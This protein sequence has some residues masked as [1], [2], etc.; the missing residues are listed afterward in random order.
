MSCVCCES[1]NTNKSW[2]FVYLGAQVELSQPLMILREFGLPTWHT[3]V[4]GGVK[5]CEGFGGLWEV[6]E[7]YESD[8]GEEDVNREMITSQLQGKLW[9]YD[10]VRL[11]VPSFLPGD[12]PIAS[13]NKAMAFLSIAIASWFLCTNNQLRTSSNPRNQATAQ[14]GRVIV[15]Q[16]QGRQG[17]GYPKRLRNSVW[18][19]EKLMLVEAQEAVQI[20][21]KE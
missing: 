10:E 18:F 17:Q 2:P 16:V 12:D 13:L 20:L 8:R 5:D 6:N 7:V 1:V 11:A 21:D 19:K 14:H 9:L 4:G 15:Q 3:H